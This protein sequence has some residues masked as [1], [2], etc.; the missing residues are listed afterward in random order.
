[1][2]R[3]RCSFTYGHMEQSYVA[4][5]WKRQKDPET[6]NTLCMVFIRTAGLCARL[7]TILTYLGQRGGDDY[8]VPAVR[9]V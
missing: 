5:K 8:I 4:A 3:G 1:M 9:S 6:S 7:S 2:E